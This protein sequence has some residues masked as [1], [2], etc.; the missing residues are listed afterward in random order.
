MNLDKI[1]SKHEEFFI[2]RNLTES[3]ENLAG[4]IYDDATY[5]AYKQQ[6]LEPFSESEDDTRNLSDLLDQQRVVI[7]ESLG[8]GQSSPD[9]IAY[10][11]GTL[12]ILTDM[13]SDELLKDGVYIKPSASPILSIVKREYY[14]ERIG[15]DGSV[16]KVKIPS[17]KVDLRGER[18]E[19]EFEVGKQYNLFEELE[20]SRDEYAISR[21][22]LKLSLLIADIGG[23]ETEVPL[24]T[25]RLNARGDVESGEIKIVDPDD[26]EHYAVYRLTGNVNN[27]T[28][29]VNVSPSF[30]SVEGD[31][32]IK[33]VRFRLK[34]RV[35]AVSGDKGIINIKTESDAKDIIA[36]D[37][38]PV[39]RLTEKP[40]IAENWK[41]IYS[42]EVMRDMSQVTRTQISINKN[43][44]IADE[45][46]D[47]EY[48]IKKNGAWRMFDI[49]PD[50]T[51]PD[52]FES[53]FKSF[54]PALNAVVDTVQT[55][56]GF[57]PNTI[58][59]SPNVAILMKSLQQV[60]TN[61][62]TKNVGSIGVVSKMADLTKFKVLKSVA[63]PDNR[64]YVVRRGMTEQDSSLVELSFK[65]LIIKSETTGGKD[66]TFIRTRTKIEV[67]REDTIGVIE[68]L[69]IDKYLGAI[70]PEA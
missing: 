56:S 60:V 4:V 17:A 66:I 48:F 12:A 1:L 15:M 32:N 8:S 69:N 55:N 54:I 46:E 33:V 52:N 42:R 34:F 31:D 11:V 40:Q 47:I 24:N 14:A 35:N 30:V 59:A 3:I 2:N 41:A 9:A 27:E 61:F 37:N 70:V 63:I 50:D 25:V 18:L 67:A 28:G 38:N 7:Q 23:T 6:L 53:I 68:L 29:T 45:L 20:V 64:M 49:I 16:D 22:G 13:Y 43:F 44:E 19:K 57:T 21:N 26:E 5:H 39:Y 62:P 36:D 65:P 10:A 58:L 51:A